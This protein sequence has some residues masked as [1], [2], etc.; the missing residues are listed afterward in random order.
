MVVTVPFCTQT[1]WDDGWGIWVF[2]CTESF[3][4]ISPLPLIT[5]LIVWSISEFVTV[6]WRENGETNFIV[7]LAGDVDD[8]L[9]GSSSF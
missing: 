2:V 3:N 5:S 8:W 7:G 6:V 4:G 9:L 1:S